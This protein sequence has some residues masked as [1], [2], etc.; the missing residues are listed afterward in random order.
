MYWL[1]QRYWRIFIAFLGMRH[2]D[3]FVK[4]HISNLYTSE[5][6]LLVPYAEDSNLMTLV[7]E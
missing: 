5:E 6:T 2:G 1:C 3:N 4:I 7:M